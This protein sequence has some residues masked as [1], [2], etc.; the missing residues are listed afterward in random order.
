M[1]EYFALDAEMKEAGVLFGGEA[2]EPVA[3]ATTIR[4]RQGDVL[5]TDGPFAETREHLGGYYV[6]DVENID[7]AMKWAAKIPAVRHGSIEVRPVMQ[8]P[9]M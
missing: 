1:M 6:V 7:E 3:T 4:V 8:L 5:H 9:E 2:L